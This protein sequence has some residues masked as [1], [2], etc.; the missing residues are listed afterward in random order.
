MSLCLSVCLS[1]C[2][3]GLP[4]PQP[5]L[6]QGWHC[7]GTSTAQAGTLRSR[8]GPKEVL[9]VPLPN[10][11]LPPGWAP[12]GW[13]GAKEELGVGE[14]HLWGLLVWQRN[15]AEHLLVLG[16]SPDPQELS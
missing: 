3:T 10:S 7:N 12:G 2:M 11:E 14:D 13:D 9:W 8:A 1:V 6:A 4:P 16:G 15:L 5:R